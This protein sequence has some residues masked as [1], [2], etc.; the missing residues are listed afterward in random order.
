MYYSNHRE[1]WQEQNPRYFADN[2]L[3]TTFRIHLENVKVLGYDFPIYR[4][5]SYKYIRKR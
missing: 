1:Q 2:I 5:V 4:K 3:Y